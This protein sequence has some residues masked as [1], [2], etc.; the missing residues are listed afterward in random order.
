MPRVLMECWSRPRQET[1][2]PPD[3]IANEA[4]DQPTEVNHWA[5]KIVL[6]DDESQWMR[7]ENYELEEKG[8]WNRVDSPVVLNKG[9]ECKQEDGWQYM[10]GYAKDCPF[11]LEMEAAVKLADSFCD[12][13]SQDH[14]YLGLQ[15]NF[16]DFV[17]KLR[18][19]IAGS[20]R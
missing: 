4:A 3:S 10:R 6:V 8:W 1:E 2:S 5:V 9:V 14:T 13:Y 7:T 15:D 12:K 20:G 19:H 16:Q 18:D 11:D 17:L